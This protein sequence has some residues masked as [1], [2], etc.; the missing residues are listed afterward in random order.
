MQELW[1]CG[2]IQL[3]FKKKPDIIRQRNEASN[4]RGT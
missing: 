3:N 1:C 4:T 2:G